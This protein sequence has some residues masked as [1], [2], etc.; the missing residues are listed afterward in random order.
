MA[1]PCQKLSSSDR[2]ACHASRRDLL[3]HFRAL[4][5]CVHDAVRAGAWM[6]TLEARLDAQRLSRAWCLLDGDGSAERDIQ[7]RKA[8]AMIPMLFCAQQLF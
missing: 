3:R 1:T 4:Q 8:R 6:C 2:S 7:R 5:I